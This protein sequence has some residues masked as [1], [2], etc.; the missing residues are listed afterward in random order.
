MAHEEMATTN[1]LI[2]ENAKLREALGPV[3]NTEWLNTCP[4][5][6]KYC[7]LEQTHIVIVNALLSAR[8]QKAGAK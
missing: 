1:Q 2:V 3:T 5:E 7:S 6:L 8:A 4:S